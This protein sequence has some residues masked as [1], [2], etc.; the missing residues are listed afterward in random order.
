MKK[1]ERTWK[2]VIITMLI[3]MHNTGS[4]LHSKLDKVVHGAQSLLISNS[5]S[6]E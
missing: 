6:Y 3:Q 5:P 1:L 4:A 2:H